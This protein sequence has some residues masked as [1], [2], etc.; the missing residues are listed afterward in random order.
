[1]ELFF[2][3]LSLV[4]FVL[5]N[6]VVEVHSLQCIVCDPSQSK[7]NCAHETLEC[8][9]ALVLKSHFEIRPANPSLPLVSPYGDAP[10]QFKCAVIETAKDD[11][12]RTGHYCTFKSTKICEGWTSRYE[13]LGCRLC[14]T[15]FCNYGL[16]FLPGEI[17]LPTVTSDMD[18]KGTGRVAVVELI[19][20]V[21]A[22]VVAFILQLI[23]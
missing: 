19:V 6:V 12:T 14:A 1:M 17:G 20:L 11:Q 23:L 9:T 7:E 3:F 13:M 4:I 10:A 8:T 5:S 16:A 22:V 15:D 18:A 2:K 21:G